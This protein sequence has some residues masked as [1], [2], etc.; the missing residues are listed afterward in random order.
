M[1]LS[2]RV[3][4]KLRPALVAALI[5]GWIAPPATAQST[6]A[7]P[8]LAAKVAISNADFRAADMWYQRALA[9]APNNPDILQGALVA[10]LAMGDLPR[11][12]Q[13]AG[14]LSG[15]GIQDQASDLAILAAAV[16]ARDYAAILQAQS[17][18]VSAGTL[19]DDLLAGWA[20]IGLGQMNDGLA[21]LQ[22]A[23]QT[24]GLAAFGLYHSAIAMALAGDFDSAVKLMASPAVEP[25]RLSRRGGI[26]Y[27]ELLSQSGQGALAIDLLENGLGLGENAQIS[28]M[29][30][31]LK[32]GKTLPISR[33]ED[34]SSGMAE[35]FF[36]LAS[37]L[38]ED[39]DPTYILLQA[40]IAATLR[41][42][43]TEAVLLTAS[44]LERLN[45]FDLAAQT[46][47]QIAPSSADYPLA[48][49]GRAEAVYSAGRKDESL[50]ILRE[51][52]AARQTD[53][54]VQIA[55]GNGLRRA[56]NHAEAIDVYTRAINLVPSIAPEHWAMFYSRA[57]SYEASGDFTRAEADFR[58][59]L[60]LNPDQPSVLNYLGYSLV[61]RGLKLD[62]ALSMIKRAVQARPD[63]GYIVDSLAW[64]YFRLGRYADALEPMERA[65]LLEPIDPVVTDHLGDVYWANGRKREAMFQWRRA[66]SFNPTEKDAARI[67][68]KIELGLDAV[69][70]REGDPPIPP[71][72]QG[73]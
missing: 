15:L 73:G 70:A 32:A 3:F 69:R 42:A 18:G 49:I 44:L 60:D 11:A 53:L 19:Q 68:L 55:L 38:G 45:Q 43:D 47:A 10:A 39:I 71:A 21:R 40:R 48:E 65:A 51:L 54:D 62:E 17:R 57:I 72:A 66:L 26:F 27:A 1:E 50:Q 9:L 63:A 35:T 2:M 59:A 33:F 28:A 6:G 8:F 30:A 31:Q 36:S 5:L 56:E 12:G 23:T 20:H 22:K 4:P 52:S 13:L 61:D 34:A 46:Y 29:I 14:D 16:Q 67:R 24:P 25:L 41:P 64:A 7:G 37:A 58:R